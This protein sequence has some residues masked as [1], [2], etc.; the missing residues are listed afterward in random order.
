[1][2]KQNFIRATSL[3]L[4]LFITFS[5]FLILL[6]AETPVEKVET[7]VEKIETPVEINQNYKL[8]PD[9]EYGVL[10]GKDN[11]LRTDI[12]PVIGL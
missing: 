12:Q 7:Q 10:A 8:N 3:F 2:E 6:K 1:M 5:V 9:F 11:K 4:L